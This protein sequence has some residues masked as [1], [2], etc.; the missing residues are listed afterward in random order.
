MEKNTEFYN[1]VKDAIEPKLEQQFM[2]GLAGGFKA[3]CAACYEEV[4]H[5]TS[6]KQIIKALKEKA[7]KE[8]N[9]VD[10]PLTVKPIKAFALFL[11]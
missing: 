11:I 1:M 8:Y 4:K 2:N 3:G 10:L 6:A 9:E 7:E 5:M